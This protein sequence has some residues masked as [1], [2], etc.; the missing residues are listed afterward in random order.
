MGVPDLNAVEIEHSSLRLL[1]DRKSATGA[2]HWR[3]RRFVA[4]KPINDD[5]HVERPATVQRSMR[6]GAGLQT[7]ASRRG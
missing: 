4:T 1:D 6:R 5:D 2:D 3:H 7:S